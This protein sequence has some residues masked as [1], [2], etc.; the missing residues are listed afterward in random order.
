MANKDLADSEKLDKLKN[1]LLEEKVF[2]LLESNLVSEIKTIS[3]EDFK[4]L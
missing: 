3:L 4:K 2:S 1:E